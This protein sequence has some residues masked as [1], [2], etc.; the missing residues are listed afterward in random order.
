MPQLSRR[1][2]IQAT[3]ASLLAAGVHS[4]RRAAAQSPA[5][6]KLNIG[7]I[8]AANRGADNARSVASENIVALCDVDERHLAQAAERYPD[9]ARYIDFR[10]MLDEHKSLDAVVISSADHTHAPAAVR[11]MRLS[12]HVYCEKPLAHTVHEARV[13]REVFLGSKVATQMGTQ[14]H[15]GSNYR[16]VV[17]LI[18]A[19]AIGAVRQA[20]VWCD[21]VSPGGDR[22]QGS[23]PVPEHLHW[24]LWLGP[25]PERPYN[26]GYHPGN[27]VWN[28]YW[29]FGNGTLGD[30]G[31][32][33]ID[34]PYWALDL[35]FPT[36]VEAHGTPVHPETNPSWLI[37]TWQHPGRG[38]GPHQQ[39][40]TLTWYDGRKRPEIETGIDLSKW[41]I[42]VIFVGDDGMLAADYGKL[43]LLPEEKFKDYQ[44]PPQT[45]PASPG[46]YR[47]WII[48]CK[49]GSPTTCNFDYSGKLIEHNLLGNVAYRLGRKLE[50]DHQN[51]RATN[52]PEA[53]K[54]IRK[55]YRAGW[56]L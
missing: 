35:A 30:M 16:R 51:L 22:P 11:A 19:G 48:A 18:Q 8:G 15:A 12:K 33:L 55:T 47:E 56:E 4:E 43:V 31:S 46:H 42:G 54:Y 9:A 29:D 39:P 36:S 52:A 34:L 20:H 37:A 53:D 23:L 10:R 24:D 3:G 38:A 2:F 49:T 21:R 40:I 25:A 1:S 28:R 26:R 41:G 50:W 6:E 7:I 32:H 5:G 27:L 45:I 14:I 44:R 17:E 13:V